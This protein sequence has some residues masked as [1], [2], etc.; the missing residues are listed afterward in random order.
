MSSSEIL[1]PCAVSGKNTYEP[2]GEAAAGGPTQQL[3]RI[4]CA[5]RWN[6]INNTPNRLAV[7]LAVGVHAVEGAEGGHVA[8]C[9]TKEG[10]RRGNSERSSHFNPW[11]DSGPTFDRAWVRSPSTRQ[12]G[13]SLLH[14]ILKSKAMMHLVHRSPW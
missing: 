4:D 1:S 14:I 6:T 7:A 2:A 10:C 5:H 8:S 11:L 9:G 13:D 3:R 12:P